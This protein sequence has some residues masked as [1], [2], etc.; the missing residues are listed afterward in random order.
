MRGDLPIGS[1]LLGYR[2]EEVL[3]RGGMGV[4]YLAEDRRLKRKVALKLLAPQLAEDERFRDRL[5]AESEL[6]A[7]LD[8][9]NIVPIYEAGE[10][11][12]RI[13][14]SMRYVEGRDLKGLLKDGQLDP[15]KTLEIVSQVASA[16]DAAHA[17][18]LVH[19]DV[20][21]SNVLVAVA[22]GREGSD[23]FY[24]ADFGLSRRLADLSIARDGRSLGT[25]A[26]VAPEQIRGEEVD[27]RA[28]LYSLGCLLF[29]CL[30]GRPPFARLSDTE[31]LFAHLEEEPPSLPGLDAVL[32]R[33]LAKSPDE[34]FQSGRELV[35]AARGA[36][37]LA[38]AS[39]GRGR[40][41]L[42]LA[43]ITLVAA[44]G[45][46]AFFVTRGGSGAAA[47]PGSDRLLRIDP[48]TNRVT[49]TIAVGRA[50][51]AIATGPGHIWVANA[52]DGSVWRIDAKTSRALKLSAQGTPTGIAVSGGTIAVADGPEHQ[53][54]F[55][56]ASSGGLSAKK[57]LT[58][59]SN[60]TLQ[61]TG[62]GQGGFWFADPAN[63]IAERT[64]VLNG[65]SFAYRTQVIRPDESNLLTA[66][67]TFDGLAAGEGAAWLAGDPLGR[68]VWRIDPRT[69]RV[70]GTLGLRFVPKAIAAGAGAVWVTSLLDDTVSRIDPQTGRIVST[71]RVGREPD[72]IATGEGAVWVADA[73]DDTV[74]RIDPTS[75]RVVGTIRVPGRPGPIAVGAGGVWVTVRHEPAIL[76]GHAIKIGVLTDCSGAI[77]GDWGDVTATA[78]ELPLIERGGRRAGTAVMDGVVGASIGGRPIRL[79][80]GCGDSTAAGALAEARRLVEKVGVDVLIGPFEAS[81]SFAVMAYARRHPRI[82]FVDAGGGAPL[83]TAPRNF[84]GFFPDGAQS[85][86]GLGDYAYRT[87]GWR[88]AV[89]VTDTSID[90]LY[91]WMQS[92]GFV[93]EFCALGGRIVKRIAIPP[94]LTDLS[95]LSD[96]IPAKGVDGVMV[97]QLSST[98]ILALAHSWPPARGNISKRLVVSS[99]ATIDGQIDGLGARAYGLVTASPNSMGYSNAAFAA[100]PA[101]ALNARYMTEARKALPRLFGFFGSADLGYYDAMTATLQALDQVHGDLSAGE[102]R[103]M[104]ALAHVVVDAPNGRTTL[105]PHHRPRAP[106]YLDQYEKPDRT[107]PERLKLSPRVF[108]IIRGVDP[109]FGGYFKASDPP[110]SVT[111]PA[112]VKRTPPPWARSSSH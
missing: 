93:A 102:T 66:Y 48:Q 46:V 78:A 24:L 11:D 68:E 84:F 83:L 47:E 75:N 44:A 79:Y 51:S 14:I 29:E 100:P 73:L 38:T 25:V 35:E 99:W 104:K 54:V 91:D 74:S 28:D 18:G 5:L 111:T 8:H 63:R 94:N 2:I 23:H 55:F 49:S 41:P 92:A 64:D 85:V 82:A 67:Q 16:L 57:V 27:G 20:K 32:R 45:L 56:D 9:P 80:F 15:T 77:N 10:A 19:R 87:L 31:V 109:T 37:G 58:G 7:S 65:P 60:Q 106:I 39:P 22:A 34:R 50:V 110:P 30:T 76:A 112:C 12:G 17:R 1:E 101:L 6:A 90:P 33:A 70:S 81:E 53:V 13:F 105:D 108:R 71:I 26:Y 62:D 43:A 72:A 40:R 103:F 86:A 98:A 4:V 21:P 69:L 89:T 95:G 59:A 61:V 36:L 107:T 52:A 42:A 3:G 88:T 96:Q 97:S